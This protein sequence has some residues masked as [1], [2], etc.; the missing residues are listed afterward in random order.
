MFNLLVFCCIEPAVVFNV[1][2]FILNRFCMLYRAINGDS[3]S[4]APLERRE[5]PGTPHRGAPAHAAH[6]RYEVC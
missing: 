4:S 2:L 3:E 1:F 5:D 6:H